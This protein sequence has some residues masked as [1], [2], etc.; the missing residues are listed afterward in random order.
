MSPISESKIAEITGAAR[1][2]RLDV[3]DMVYRQQSGHLGGSLSAAEVLACLYFHYLRLD[4]SDACWPGRDRFL[5][6]KGHAAPALYSVL[7]LVGILPRETLASFR[8]LDSLLQGHPDCNKTAGVEMGAGPL[9]HGISVA[10]GMA[11]AAR[12]DGLD[13]RTYVLL[14]DGELQAG[15]IWEGIMEAAKWRLDNLTAIVDNNGVQLDGIL[16]EI[17]PMEP[18]PDKWRAFGWHVIEA[19]GHDVRSLVAALDEAT[20]TVGRPTVVIAHT[21]KGKGVSF[22][23]GKSAWH[24]KA[25]GKTQYEQAREELE[26]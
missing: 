3:L 12:L 4:S 11:L 13:Y 15:I 17:M 21:V 25:P 14:G 16:A 1:Q 19:D 8:N 18:L 2:I 26:V 9:G 23:E 5:L 24:G 22:M 20:Q 10:V 6:S 7:S